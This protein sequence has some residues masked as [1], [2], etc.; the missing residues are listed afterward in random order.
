MIERIMKDLIVCAVAIVACCSYDPAHSTLPPYD[1]MRYCGS[2]KRDAHGEIIRNAN[3]P[4]VFQKLHPCPSTG[5]PT[6]ACPGYAA[7]HSIPLACG[8]CDAVS[9]MTWMDTITK[10]RKDA[11]ERRIYANSPPYPDTGACVFRITPPPP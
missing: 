1:E 8:G 5:L 9:N 11:Y 6:G 3:V 10:K 4:R 2:P 7:D